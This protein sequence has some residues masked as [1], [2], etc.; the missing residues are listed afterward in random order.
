MS[1]TVV[2]VRAWD[3]EAGGAVELSN[4]QCGF[5]YRTSIFNTSARGRYVVLEVTY[6]LHPG[7]PTTLAY[8]DV[9]EHFAAGSAAPSL[10]EVREAV[11]KIR[12]SK[13]MVIDEADPNRRSAGS[14]FKNPVVEKSRAEALERDLGGGLPMFPAGDGRIKLPAARLIES[15][16]FEKGYRAGAVGISTRH[17]LALVNLG[18]AT[19]EALLG[20]A[21]EIQSAVR[22]RF[23]VELVPEPVFLGFGA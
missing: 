14:F 8:Q 12:R 17:T 3:L 15:A 7:G 22:G 13:S 9:R 10:A 23:G 11:L 1:R 20:L 21:R 2:S 16:G 6:R 5:E 4:A 18:G 19:A